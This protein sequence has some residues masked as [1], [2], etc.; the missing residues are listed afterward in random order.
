M[1]EMRKRQQRQV[2]DQGLDDDGP[3]PV[4]DPSV[5]PLEPEEQRACDHAEETEVDQGPQVRRRAG[6]GRHRHGFENAERFGSYVQAFDAG[7]AKIAHA[8]SQNVFLDR[9]LGLGILR[10]LG[11]IDLM[12]Q[13]D[14]GRV[15]DVVRQKDRGEILIHHAGPVERTRQG[16]AAT[17]LLDVE[18]LGLVVVLVLDA[19]GGIG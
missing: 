19:A 7:S 9:L 2:D 5:R 14:H 3:S 10:I 15:L 4:M 1:L 13:R 11:H 18:A 16:R 17:D 6:Q 8:D 12:P